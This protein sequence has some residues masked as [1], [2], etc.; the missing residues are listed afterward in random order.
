MTFANVAGVFTGNTFLSG[1]GL[2][3]GD[4]FT[5]RY[6]DLATDQWVVTGV[7]DNTP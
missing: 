4:S 3:P 6:L 1:T 7:Q 2:G 5:M